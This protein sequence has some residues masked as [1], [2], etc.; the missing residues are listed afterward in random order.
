[1]NMPS[2]EIMFSELSDMG[3]GTSSAQIIAF[4]RPGS[5]KGPL[6][7]LPGTKAES[8]PDG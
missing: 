5:D 7:V 1:M 8:N 3:G 2:M 4:D 6:D